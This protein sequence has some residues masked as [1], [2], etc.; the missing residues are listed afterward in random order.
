MKNLKLILI[1]LLVSVAYVAETSAGSFKTDP[2]KN[3][4]YISVSQVNHVPGLAEAM[5]RSLNPNFLKKDMQSYTV[6]FYWL[7]IIYVVSGSYEQWADFFWPKV[8]MPGTQRSDKRV[9]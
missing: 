9:S 1:A 5:Q 3:K 4:V 2:N 8:V 6:T 7:N